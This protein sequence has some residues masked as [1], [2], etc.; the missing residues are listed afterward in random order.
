MLDEVNQGNRD[1]G[2]QG[3]NRRSTPSASTRESDR[4]Q[5][6]THNIDESG[7]AGDCSKSVTVSD[8]SDDNEAPPTKKS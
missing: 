5:G 2:L 3:G 8:I 7:E 6:Q 4:G 1:A